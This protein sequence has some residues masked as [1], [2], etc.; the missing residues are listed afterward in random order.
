MPIAGA[1]L[2][3]SSNIFADGWTRRSGTDIIS[4]LVTMHRLITGSHPEQMASQHP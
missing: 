2:A 4:S 1:D 3:A